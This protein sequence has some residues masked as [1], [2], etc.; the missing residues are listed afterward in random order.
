MNVQTPNLQ[1]KEPNALE[2][3]MLAMGRAAREAAGHLREASGEQKNKALL[4][5]ADAIR[6]AQTQILAANDEDMKAG[7]ARN[8][9][10]ALMDRL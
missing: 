2:A 7:A 5:A 6:S 3:D 4:A 10:P 8:L 1:A 9:T